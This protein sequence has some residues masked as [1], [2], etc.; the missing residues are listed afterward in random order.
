[1]PLRA[2]RYVK[3]ESQLD[4]R[5]NVHMIH[6]N[7]ALKT[8]RSFG[9]VAFIPCPNACRQT[10]AAKGKSWGKSSSCQ[11]NL[12]LV[13]RQQLPGA[14]ILHYDGVFI[15]SIALLPRR[16]SRHSPDGKG[17]RAPEPCWFVLQEKNSSPSMQPYAPP[18]GR[19]MVYQTLTLE[20][21]SNWVHILSQSS[22]RTLS[23]KAACT[24]KRRRPQGARRQ[25]HH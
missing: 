15:S 2:S 12:L 3:L 10:T 5:Q 22:Q 14:T 19:G 25:L 4:Q 7:E 9:D 8:G 24:S 20:C 1:M 18:S 23:T 21:P 13:I 17:L 6:I 11:C 16:S